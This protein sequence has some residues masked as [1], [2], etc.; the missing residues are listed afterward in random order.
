MAEKPEVFT[1]Q[2][3]EK[4]LAPFDPQRANRDVAADS[5]GLMTRLMG[6]L[7]GFANGFWTPGT[8]L[9][10]IPPEGTPP[11]QFDFRTT[12]NIDIAPRSNSAISFEQLRQLADNWDVLRAIIQRR[13]EHMSKLKW[14]IQPR[15][16]EED[17][18][19]AGKAIE[20]Q[21]AYPDNEHD[22]G[23]FQSA[24][25]ED[26]LVLDA[27]AVQPVLR[28]DGSVYGFFGMDGAT[29]QV[30]IDERGRTPQPPNTAYQQVIKGVPWANFTKDELIYRPWNYRFSS[31]FGYSKVEQ[32]V[33]LINIGL[34]RQSQQLYAFTDG[35]LP[36]TLMD[37]P[38]GWTPQQ[39]AEYQD[40]FDSRYTG[41]LKKRSKVTFV[42]HGSK[43]VAVQTDPLKNEFDEWC[44]RLAC[45]IFG[46]SP[47]GLVK[48]MNRA[49]AE[50]SKEKASQ[51][52]LEPTMAYIENWWNYVLAFYYKRPDLCFHFNIED[53]QDPKVENE[54]FMEQIDRGALSVDD[55]L[56]MK[57]REPIGLGPTLKTPSGPILVS[58]FLAQGGTCAPAAPAPEPGEIPDGPPSGKAAKSALPAGHLSRLPMPKGAVKKNS[59]LR[60]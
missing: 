33:I 3:T 41:N 6:G 48:E 31:M 53:E 42:P 28:P 58:T 5:Q 38:E 9:P 26:L 11:R 35:T 49:S 46:E 60:Y 25:L 21:L 52:G 56:K 10:T 43:A 54:I 17:L 1:F 27:L 20:A 15:D 39:I 22:F 55:F 24:M 12:T 13:K 23:T 36:A 30:K 4:S 51:E 2:P 18:D 8:P 45:F 37:T 50:T 29:I 47:Q 57:G 34:R 14:T 16:G 40:R 44:A 7:K 32:L 59:K 19:E